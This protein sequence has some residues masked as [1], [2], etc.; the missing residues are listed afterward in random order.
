MSL[1]RMAE[2]ERL[3]EEWADWATDE[4]YWMNN[5]LEEMDLETPRQLR[6]RTY[7]VLGIVKEAPDA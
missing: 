5:C 7:R 6:D 2:L 1:E 4:E 3:L